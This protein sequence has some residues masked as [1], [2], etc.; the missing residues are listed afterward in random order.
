MDPFEDLDRRLRESREAVR[1]F[2]HL[3]ARRSTVATQLR[4]VA[5]AV[6]RLEAELAEERR[7][8]TRLEGGFTGFLAGLTGGRQERLTRER[9]E[10][11]AAAERLDGQRRR[12][13]DLTADLQH[14]DRELS[15]LAGAGE[16]H[17][18]VLAEKERLLVRLA[19]PR[20]QRLTELTT[21]LAD[22]EAGL[23]EHEEAV[24]AGATAGRA[25]TEMLTL[26]DRA[27]Q[28]STWDLLGG[29]AHADAVER[30]HL[31][32]ADQVAWHAQ[33]ALDV[34]ARELA[35][36]GWTATPRLPTVDTRWFADTF[37]DNIITD[38]LKHQRINRTRD[39]V[40]AMSQWIDTS[41]HTLS[42]RKDDLAH[43]RTR[44]HHEREHLLTP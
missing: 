37:F 36:V 15:Q 43:R 9:A 27:R 12:L 6:A 35:D 3:A 16:T 14:T 1:R 11:E 4:E 5:E 22:T 32:A 41:L 29:G 7:D 40:T 28:A 23:R 26:L 17:D 8:V 39:A 38:A 21:E 33:R 30:H 18:H 13:A 24:R 31:K 44:L 25:V 20:A 42:Q 2:D 19:D 10:A 34:Y